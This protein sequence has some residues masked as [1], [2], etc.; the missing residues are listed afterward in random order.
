MKFEGGSNIALKIPLDKYEEMVHFYRDVLLLDVTEESIEHP[1]VS[2][3]HRVKFGSNVLWLDCVDRFTESQVWL[4]IRVLDRS[5][6]VPYLL[7]NGV[8]VDDE[9]E[10]I[11]DTMHWI[12][13]PAGTVMILT[14]A[15][16]A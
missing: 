2:R 7:S 11:P 16:E 4:E 9:L 1:T 6:P 10:K 14:P 13:D 15:D 5:D 3:T 8:E 12:R